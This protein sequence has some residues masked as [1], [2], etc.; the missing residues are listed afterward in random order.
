MP[1]RRWTRG[2]RLA[3]AMRN[4]LG[5][6][7]R[8][9]AAPAVA[10]RDL[11][12]GNAAGGERLVRNQ[13]LF[14][15]TQR[16]LIDGEW[17]N[18]QWP[19][20]YRRW[21]QGFTWL[22]DLRELGA[23]SARIKAR[24]LVAQW[25]EQ[26]PAERP[27]SDPS[28]TGARLAAWLGCYEFFAASAD[29]SFRQQ[30]MASLIMEARSIM[31][32]MP[33]ETTGW[34]AL[35]ALKG[36]LAVAVS[37]PDYP[38]FLTRYLRLIDATISQQILP[39]GGHI[40]RCP[41]DLLQCVRE[42]AEMLYILQVA[43]VPLPTSVLDAANRS[44]PALRAMRHGDGG[45]ALFNGSSEQNPQ[46]IEHVLNRAS[47][48]R[49]VAAG[50][51][52]SGFARLNNGRALLIADAATVAPA[53]YDSSAHA[54][55][56]SFEFSSGRQRLIVNCGSS[57]QRG[58]AEALRYPAAHSVLELAD[59]TPMRFD[60]NGG[61]S[62]KPQVTRQMSVQ[63]GVHCLSMTHD[64][65]KPQGG[66]LYSRKI[67]L[68]KDGTVL[69]GIEKL[70][71]VS[72]PVPLCIRFHLHPDV[73]IEQEED[74]Y[75]L[76][77]PEETWFFWS[78]ADIEIEESVYLGQGQ[79]QPTRQF[80]LTPAV[81]EQTAEE[82]HDPLDTH[83]AEEAALPA[84]AISPM[85]HT[86]EVPE[87]GT[88]LLAEPSGPDANGLENTLLPPPPVPQAPSKP[89]IRWSLSLKNA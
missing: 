21:L 44:A 80:V 18:S 82:A 15:G 39:D 81:A 1:L 70:E 5:G 49:V 88:G 7:A 2:A 71:D 6:F 75:L 55:M 76:H 52:E 14:E 61:I 83:P 25:M 79:H 40:T 43:R 63:D 65:Y 35:T 33:E 45:L 51:P 23:E 8:V 57:I 53:G 28:I 38:E 29:D 54:G 22:Q 42:L 66:G 37:L 30:L 60:A 56:L 27:I 59:L 24:T 11:W 26:T 50:L 86:P 47:R 64:G 12:S 84:E 58:W 34:R 13:T 36:L 32:L 16:P 68:D 41:E 48:T 89:P 4:P 10:L 78:D 77:T 3:Y 72:I 62:Q 19:E 69:Q 67:Y 17:D 74:G 46:F 31:A 9:P 73:S 20:A 87:V 85:D